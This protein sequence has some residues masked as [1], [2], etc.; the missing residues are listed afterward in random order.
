VPVI[1]EVDMTFSERLHELKDASGL[2]WNEIAR[3]AGLSMN[4]MNDYA[5]RGKVPSAIV[6][7]K[8]AEGIGVSCDSFKLQARTPR[9]QPA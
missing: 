8:L 4:S 6:L 9:L 7:F 3:R 2:S 5:H 1:A